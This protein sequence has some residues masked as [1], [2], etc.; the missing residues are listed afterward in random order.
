MVRARCCP[1]GLDTHDVSNFSKDCQSFLA[2]PLSAELNGIE[3]TPAV[4]VN[5]L[6]MTK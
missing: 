1:A 5:P 6:L 2:L 4:R 3:L